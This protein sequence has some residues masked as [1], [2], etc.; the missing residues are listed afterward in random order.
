MSI[1]VRNG[2]AFIEGAFVRADVRIRDGRIAAL[3]ALSP[4]ATE[5][6]P[7]HNARY[8]PDDR[9]LPY[10]A[11]MLAYLA[12]RELESPSTEAR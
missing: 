6:I 7:G 9:A 8:L 3:G 5:C 10:G 1:L 11:A 2:T 12:M 4:E